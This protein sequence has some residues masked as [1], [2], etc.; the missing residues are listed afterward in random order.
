MPDIR[1]LFSSRRPIDRNIEKVID[2]YA[3]AEDRLSAEVEEYEVT[4]KVEACFR[5]FLDVYSDG[6]QGG[7]V[8]EVG[9]WVSGFYGSGKSSFTKYL[10]FALDPDRKIGDRP[11]LDLLSD[12]FQRPEVP[13]LLRTVARRHPT[14]VVLLDL[15]AEQLAESAAV[16]VSTVLYRKVLQWAGYS[17]EKKLARLELTLE[18]EGKREDF[19]AKYKERFGQEWETIHNDPLLGIAR[20]AEIVPEVM[21]SEFK[22]PESF[23][24]FRFEEATNLRDLAS[25]MIDICRRRKGHENI[26]FLIDE[27]G[28]YVAPRGELILNLDGLA[29]NLKELGQGKVWVVATGQQTL[30]EIVEKAAYNSAE[31]IKLRD[32]FPISIHLD[33]SDIRE[34]TYRRLL[35]KSP[36]GE[37]SL[38]DSFAAHGQSLIT[39]TRLTGTALFKG[40][41]DSVTFSRLYPFLPQHFDLL[42]ELIRRLARS[43]GGVGL[44]S[45]IRVIQ[46]VLVDKSKILPAGA[47]KL[48]ERRVGTLAC[49]DDFYNTLRADIA[50]VLPHVVAGVDKVLAAFSSDTLA[51]RVAKAVAAL[52]PIETFPRTAENIA[53]LL[54]PELGSS[55]L[56]D[57]VHQ[58]L[59]AIVDAKEPGLIEDPQAG[60]YAFLSEAVRP[61][62]EKRNS[63]VPTSGETARVKTDIL[64]QGVPEY[65]L[66]SAQPSARLDNVKEVRAVVKLGRTPVVGSTEEIS[67]SLEFIEP[68]SWERRRTELLVETNAK[69]ELKSTIVWLARSDDAVEE[70]LQEIVRSDKILRDSGDERQEDHDVAQFLRSERR[71]AEHNREQIAKLLNIAL[72]EGTLFFRGRQTPASVAGAH[73]QHASQTV[74][75]AAAKDVFSLY[76][77]VPVR[78]PT[79]MAAKFLSV[80]R[81]DRMPRDLDPLGLIS[82]RGG[83][84]R[85]D[86]SNAALAE[87]L[88]AF[89]AKAEESG[90]G[91]LQGN[92]LQDFFSSPPY[93]WSKDAVRYLFAALLAAHEI[94]LHVPGADGPLR[95]PGPQAVEAVKSTVSFNRVGVSLRDSKPTPESLDLAASRL[96]QLFGGIEVLPLEDQIN[97]AV[98]KHMP[99]VLERVG[100]LPDRLRLLDLT[101]EERAKNLIAS[102]TD[103]LKSDASDAAAVLGSKD[104]SIPEDVRWAKSIV[105]ALEDGLERELRRARSLLASVRELQD[106]FPAAFD[107]LALTED[108]G[109]VNEILNSPQFYEQIP[110]LRGA[111]RKI[112]DQASARYRTE[113]D[114][115][116][117]EMETAQSNL[118]ADIDWPRLTDDDREE[119]VTRSFRGVV[120][121]PDQE[122][123]IRSLLSLIVHRS[124]LRR[125][126]EEARREVKSRVPPEPQPVGETGEVGSEVVTV[127]AEALITPAVLRTPED[128]D[129]WLASLRVKLLSMLR[130]SRG[131]NIEGRLVGQSSFVQAPSGEEERQQTE[132]GS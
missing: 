74:I 113:H 12:R 115:Y 61:L 105:A 20:A 90:S 127:S 128:V 100:S 99:G 129:D 102:I 131:L 51:Q 11:F 37:R 33:A 52:Q 42:L 55:S 46:D 81:L 98:R 15:G 19:R 44:R 40:D 119:I 25:E 88:R 14:T 86:A 91:R 66:F 69:A 79:D 84:A 75:G 67:I 123:P 83:G 41:P 89:R 30:S 34:I 21:P 120:E 45:A 103:L 35:T 78:P 107:S 5:R 39:H 48:S 38:N 10:G 106:L 124:S 22:T 94:E 68:G 36:E 118:E 58:A 80:E 60:G 116:R 17:K 114:S 104:C 121:E 126:L 8:T 108:V 6:V 109:A 16:S 72:M 59:R 2:Y 130:A 9:V 110:D 96:E 73:L 125:Q 32:R 53:A 3:Q 85:V 7:R 70:M 50:K 63:Y 47:T 92:S 111:L 132:V 97:N 24:T 29:R 26:L 95:T 65:P 93:G 43:T 76:H 64:R 117:R 13:A 49:V 23:R 1:S 87:V 122:D 4:E 28:Q 54:Y 101:G 112:K 71:L 82:R 62:R 77:L 18:R 27:A 57:E 56:H 31:L